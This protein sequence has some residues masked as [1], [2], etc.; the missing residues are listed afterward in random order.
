MKGVY[1]MDYELL[2][3]G[4]VKIGQ[5]APDFS[6]TTTLGDISLSNYKGGWVVLFSHP[7]RFYASMYN[8]IYSI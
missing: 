8:R 3:N 4:V 2:M 7:R 6:A 1:F 5:I